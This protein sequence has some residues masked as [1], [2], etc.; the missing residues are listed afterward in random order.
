MKK[1]KLLYALLCAVGGC[2]IGLEY[3]K[4][5]YLIDSLVMMMMMLIYMLK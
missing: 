1:M 3:W 2:I 4:L 5:F